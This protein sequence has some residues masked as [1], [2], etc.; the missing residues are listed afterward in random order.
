MLGWLKD[1]IPWETFVFLVYLVLGQIRC[2]GSR[3]QL[4]LRAEKCAE[5]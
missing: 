1:R 5:E 2:A 4:I 3:K